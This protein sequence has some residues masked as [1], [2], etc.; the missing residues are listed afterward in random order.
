MWHLYDAQDVSCRP[1]DC[2]SHQ[3]FHIA[4]H[5]AH[6]DGSSLSSHHL[7]Y[8]FPAN[9]AGIY[10]SPK[11]ARA[12]FDPLLR[13]KGVNIALGDVWLPLYSFDVG[14]NTISEA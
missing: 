14:L 5:I 4:R 9:L 2:P 7:P 11:I 10:Q 8:G 3:S 1:C 6:E 12:R 13:C